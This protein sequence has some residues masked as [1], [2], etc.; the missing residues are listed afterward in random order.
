MTKRRSSK[1]AIIVSIIS[2]LLCLTMFL[3]S[4]YAW[5][6]DSETS[7]NNIIKSGNLDVE[8]LWSTDGKSWESVTEKTNVF[9][10]YT[11][12]EP[13]HTQVVYL[14]VINKGSLALKYN[15]SVNVADEKGSTNKDGQPFKLSDHIMYGIT[16]FTAPYS[17][18]SAAR[19]A[20]SPLAK[21]LNESYLDGNVALY[22]E[23]NKDGLVTEK[24]VAMVVYMPEEVGNEAN[25]AKGAPTPIIELGINL[26]AT[27]LPY[28]DDSFGNDYDAN[29]QYPTSTTVKIPANS[30]EATE[31][32]AGKVSL[33]LPAALPEGEYTL[34]V[35]TVT[36]ETD[37]NN[38]TTLTYEIDLLRNGEKVSATAGISYPVEIYV[39]TGLNIIEVTHNGLPIA[40]YTY[41]EQSGTVAFETDSFSPF[42]VTYSVKD[43]DEGGEPDEG[44]DGEETTEFITF[45]EFVAE[46]TER[47]GAFDGAGREVLVTNK[48]GTQISDTVTQFFVGG[49]GYDDVNAL[50]QLYITDATFTFGFS[51]DE[52]ATAA[53]GE[54][55][56]LTNVASF[57]GCTFNGLSVTPWGADAE[58]EQCNQYHFE[59]CTF[60]NIYVQHPINESKADNLIVIDS[61]FKNGC[62]GIYIDTPTP[63]Y[64]SFENNTF[65]TRSDE[66]GILRIGT[67][68]NYEALAKVSVMNNTVNADT[69]LLFQQNVTVTEE[70]AML[71]ANGFVGYGELFT[72]DSIIA[73]PEP[74]APPS[75]GGDNE[76][77]DG[78]GGG[79]IE[80]GENE[81]G[82]NEGEGGDTDTT[83]TF[84]EFVQLLRE[85][86]YYLNDGTELTVT[87]KYSN[88][89]SVKN[90]MCSFIVDATTQYVQIEDVTFVYDDEGNNT[91]RA[92][93]SIN[94]TMIYFH[95]CTFTGVSADCYGDGD[96][97]YFEGCEFND[98]KGYAI[99]NTTR[100]I[101]AARCEF[102]NC[103]GVLYTN[104]ADAEYV[105]LEYN[106]VHNLENVPTQAV[107]F[108]GEYGDYSRVK[109]EISDTIA[110]AYAM[111]RIRND[112]VQYND[113]MA[114]LNNNAYRTPYTSDSIIPQ[115]PAEDNNTTT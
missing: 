81:G 33:T 85:S 90:G 113:V 41:N 110:P 58:G 91:S 28:E 86:N 72:D 97:T 19:A 8:L 31:M 47:D 37:S 83:L 82:D 56:I 53:E 17:D 18:R 45:E 14:K 99:T 15:L 20:A 112:T 92:Q 89:T 66:C 27:H 35:P 96:N 109:I 57:I 54:L 111:L 21:K 115:A 11:L 3:G 6:T 55:V 108:I 13:G 46:L 114:I 68:G 30:T 59:E 62:G 105:S 7:T 50:S 67:L 106:S 40:N 32:T 93:I 10:K 87:L 60:D 29:A 5:F 102:R 26:T 2:V 103:M 107:L 75:G 36:T 63:T 23:G 84:P 98:I 100:G 48:Y 69:Q 88:A 16:D 61:T 9:E 70:I 94:G 4:T 25:A 65:E 42:A 71:F 22:P 1:N 101:S 12:W 51:P 80:G 78:T 79:E 24:T 64:F 44:G 49:S 39:G 52:T 73:M 104:S 43:A 34:S 38:N 77:G 74:P 76:G 95:N